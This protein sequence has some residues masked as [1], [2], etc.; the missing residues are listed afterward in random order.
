MPR[1]LIRLQP[2]VLE[3]TAEQAKALKAIETRRSQ[4]VTR[5]QELEGPAEHD[6]AAAKEVDQLDE[7]QDDLEK[8]A[9]FLSVSPR[10]AQARD[11]DRGA[12]STD[13]R[14]RP[15]AEYLGLNRSQ[16]AVICT[17][18]DIILIGARYVAWSTP[19][20]SGKDMSQ[21]RLD[22]AVQRPKCA[23]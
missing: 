4:I 22:A 5:L 14:P 15:G 13:H 18:T 8:K 16:T 6:E 1:G 9:P 2:E 10:L 7:E 21:E 12:R 11:D 19:S 20:P 17:E 23:P 3:P